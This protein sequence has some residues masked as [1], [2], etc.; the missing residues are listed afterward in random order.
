MNKKAY[1]VLVFL[2]GFSL[3]A[4]FVSCSPVQF[5]KDQLAPQNAGPA[6]VTPVSCTAGT[7]T[8]HHVD[9]TTGAKPQANVLFILDTSGSTTDIQANMAAYL[10][11]FVQ[12]LAGVDYRIGL[13]TTD[14]SSSVSDSKNNYADSSNYNGAVQDGR[15]VQLNDGSYYLT[16]ASSTTSI[17]APQIIQ[18]ASNCISSNYNESICL[19]DDP[20]A[21]F[22]ADLMV[23][24]NNNSFIRAGVPTTFIIISDADERNSTSLATHGFPQGASDAPSS[25]VSTFQANF[26]STPFQVDALVIRP[27]D[28]GCFNQRSSRSNG[29][30]LIFGFYAPIYASLVQQTGGVLGSVCSSNFAAQIGAIPSAATASSQIHSLTLACSP[31]QGL[32][33]L[34]FT[35]AN[36]NPVTNIQATPDLNNKKINL[37]PTLPPNTHAILS[38]DCEV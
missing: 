5:T 11:G 16:P 29:N 21:I 36:G 6:I 9:T 15:L 38:Y 28:Q 10:D 19:S 14:T 17:S 18:S 32:F 37:S 24:S 33:T 2:F 22:A 13:M 25:L 26:P 3:L 20:R 30:P 34:S 23:S 27:G 7:C 4:D 31:Y 8:Q 12:G 35:D 1:S